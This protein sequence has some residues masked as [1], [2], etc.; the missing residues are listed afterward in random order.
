MVFFFQTTMLTL[1]QILFV[2]DISRVA[3]WNDEP[4]VCEK[5]QY[6]KIRIKKNFN[7]ENIYQLLAHR[8][9]SNP[10]TYYH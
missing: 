2:R 8:I 9:T 6:G 1:N 10:D 7:S 4:S 5:C 3:I